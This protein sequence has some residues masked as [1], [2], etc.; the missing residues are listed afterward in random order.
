MEVQVLSRAPKSVFSQ[1]LKSMIFFSQLI[2]V[3]IIDN[4]QDH[5]GLLK[6][7]VV[8]ANSEQYPQVSA[9]VFKYKKKQFVIPYQYIENFGQGQITLKKSNCWEKKYEF[10]QDEIL[11]RRDLLDQQIFDVSGIRVVRVNDLEL[12]KIKEKFVLMGIDISNKAILRRLGLI[13][14]P[15]VNKLEAKFI[16]WNNV[17]LVKGSGGNLQLNTSQ[18][19]LAK[20]HPADI[21][22][23]I[24]NLNF[25]ES[26]K[27][28]QALDEET[29]AEVLEE[30]EPKYKETLLQQIS[31]KS[32]AEIVEE[33]PS[34]EA[35]DVMQ[36]LSEDKR[37][38]IYKRLGTQKAR[39]IHQ[40]TGYPENVAGGLMNA[41]FMVVAKEDTV[42]KAI[43]KI[44]KASEDHSSIYH[45]FVANEENQLEGIVSLRTLLLA[46]PEVKIEDIMSKVVKMLKITTEAQEVASI[47]TK[48]NLLSVAVVDRRKV[49]Q[50]IITVDDVLRFLIPDA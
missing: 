7:V 20:L 39:R 13:H 22:N 12:A 5:I 21:A 32:L 14:I 15:F 36:E 26:T 2:K 4:K 41:D 11:L 10:S 19:K 6:D 40:L 16:D 17:S 30:V 28:V 23:L 33:M 38:Q 3:P 9:I 45:V 31:A 24:E 46:K 18:E 48:Y 25:Q 50:G 34:D 1:Y 35:V 8:K 47:M 49:I 44:R 37:Q 27:L 29:A 43:Q 42:K